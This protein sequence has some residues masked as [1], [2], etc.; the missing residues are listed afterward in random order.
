MQ[1]G[2]EFEGIKTGTTFPLD[3]HIDQDK[4]TEFLEQRF[5]EA[6][7]NADPTNQASHDEVGADDCGARRI[8]SGR[9]SANTRRHHLIT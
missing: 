5:M 3:R 7:A 4:L 6:M 9:L 2:D 1:R 8:Q